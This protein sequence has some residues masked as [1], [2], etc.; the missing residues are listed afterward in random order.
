MKHLALVAAIS[1]LAMVGCTTNNTTPVNKDSRM[2]S[3]QGEMHRG[4]H[5][6][7]GRH[8]EGRGSRARQ[9]VYQCEQGTTIAERRTP[10][11]DI[12]SLTVNAPTLSLSNQVI[13]LKQA[14]S[15]SGER[16][17]NDTNPASIYEW[18]A[19]GPEGVF[20]VTVNNQEYN[21]ICQAANPRT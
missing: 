14:T 19:K 6:H 1:T 12:I 9:P 13:E 17:V 7:G 15:G 5:A 20:T 3:G 18:H 16:F 10:N 8:Q 21:Y 2:V 4:H 11:S